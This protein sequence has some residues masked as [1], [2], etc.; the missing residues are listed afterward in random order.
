LAAV[1]KEKFNFETELIADHGGAFLVSVNGDTIYDKKAN[2]GNFPEHV[3]IL[4]SI[5]KILA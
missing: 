1:I 2:D 3:E 4:D 5:K